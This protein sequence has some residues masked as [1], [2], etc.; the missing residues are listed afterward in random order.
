MSNRASVVNDTVFSDAENKIVEVKNYLVNQSSLTEEL[1]DL[2]NIIKGLKDSLEQYES[3]KRAITPKENVVLC[4]FE[5]YTLLF[6]P[7]AKY[8]RFVVAFGFDSK[9]GEW[10]QGKYFSDLG[11]AYD[12]ADPEIIETATIKWCKEDIK[13]RLISF[14]IKPT[15]F[16]IA[17]TIKPLS[18][19]K[20]LGSCIREY[21][22][23]N[24]YEIL[25]E[26]IQIIKERDLYD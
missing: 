8:N 4:E 7:T 2:L 6:D 17:T 9:T 5:R 3:R 15:E 11:Q 16:N 22:I 24:G 12:Y 20:S 10:S 1:D 23:M 25:D 18:G 21:G 26:Q 19:I 13:E 14:G